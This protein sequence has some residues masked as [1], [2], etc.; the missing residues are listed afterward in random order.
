[1]PAIIVEFRRSDSIKELR[2]E[3]KNLKWINKRS[4]DRLNKLEL[5]VK[6]NALSNK[7]PNQVNILFFHLDYLI[8][9]TVL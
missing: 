3:V 1:V 9:S 2:K 7:P 4:E 8:S 6:Q 5:I